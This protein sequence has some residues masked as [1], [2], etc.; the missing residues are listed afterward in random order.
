MSDRYFVYENWTNT[1]VKVHR[2][3]CPYCNE[4][5]GMHGRGRKTQSGQ[6]SDSFSS[7]EEA[8]AFARSVVETYANRS[9]WTT[10]LCSYCC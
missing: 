3:S 6:W 9:V 7:R 10:G 5:N 4:G 8:M 2:G 1:F